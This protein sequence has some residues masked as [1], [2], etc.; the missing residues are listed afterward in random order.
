MTHFTE[1]FSYDFT[2]DMESQL[3]DIEYG[4]VKQDDVIRT[5]LS[6]LDKHIQETKELYQSNPDKIKKTKDTSLHCGSYQND[7]IYFQPKL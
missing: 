4:T 3:D 1:M 7:P 6:S 2:N 5:Y